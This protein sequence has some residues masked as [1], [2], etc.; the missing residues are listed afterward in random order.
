MLITNPMTFAK[1]RNCNARGQKAAFPKFEATATFA[2][3]IRRAE[4]NL[5]DRLDREITL[6]RMIRERLQMKG[7]VAA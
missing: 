6:R 2:A 3:R 5:I 7:L 1:A 4:D